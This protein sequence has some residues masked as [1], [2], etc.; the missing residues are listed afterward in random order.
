MSADHA[1][2]SAFES[3]PHEPSPG[4][5]SDAAGKT[6]ATR[7]PDDFTPP[8]RLQYQLGVYLATNAITDAYAVIDGPD[9]L[10]RKAEW[11]HGKHDFSSTL[12]DV[13]GNH[14]IVSTLVNAEAVIKDRGDMLAERV[15]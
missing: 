8:Y 13:F 14:R 3:K 5:A 4:A 2:E 6:I 15:R 9:C 11:V 12:L 10:F 1:I 7:E